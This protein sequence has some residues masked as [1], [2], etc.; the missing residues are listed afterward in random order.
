MQPTQADVART[1]LAGYH[2]PHRDPAEPGYENLALYC[3][4]RYL[5]RCEAAG[6]EPDRL[7]LATYLE[8]CSHWKPNATDASPN[9]A[10]EPA[11]DAAEEAAPSPQPIEEPTAVNSHAHAAPSAN[12]HTNE[13]QARAAS[14]A[15]LEAHAASAGYPP[16]APTAIY[17]AVI[18][19]AIAAY[20]AQHP[21]WTTA[22]LRSQ[23]RE[24]FR[25][26]NVFG[27]EQ[28]RAAYS[29]TFD[30]ALDAVLPAEPEPQP[31]DDAI[32]LAPVGPYRVEEGSFGYRVVDAETGRALAVV[33]GGTSREAHAVAHH[34]AAADLL[35]VAA[36]SALGR[37]QGI[38]ARLKQLSALVY[39]PPGQAEALAAEIALCQDALKKAFD[40]PEGVSIDR[41]EITRVA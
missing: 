28:A 38:H 30:D 21:G 32:T 15:G 20:R 10:A 34:L 26:A 5:R 1:I 24:T 27:D 29:A 22:Q 6:F 2:L 14:H 31:A 25:L 19:E 37:L 40:L 16:R 7:N 12:G 9:G 23:V 17:R 13:R 36:A 33:L 39:L 3:A 18:R 41:L 11:A 35:T 4:R 8:N